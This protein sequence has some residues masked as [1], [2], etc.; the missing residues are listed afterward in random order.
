M[1]QSPHQSDCSCPPCVTRRRERKLYRLQRE[2]GMRRMCDGERCRAHLEWLRE[3]G[4]GQT[5]VAFGTGL[6][7][8]TLWLIAT[9]RRSRVMNETARRI[10]S[11]TP[12]A[13]KAIGVDRPVDATATRL[14]V[15]ALAALGYPQDFIARRCGRS[16][17]GFDMGQRI[18]QRRAL[19][20]LELCREIGDTP[21]PSRK[22]AVQ[23][24][25]RGWCTPAAW[26][27]ELFYDPAWGGSEP[28]TT[29]TI[30]VDR[31][32]EYLR[33]HDWLA[34]AGIVQAEIARRLGIT[35]GYLQQLLN[36]RSQR[37]SKPLAATG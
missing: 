15:Q 28:T 1:G 17:G 37:A 18:S 5:T 9:G 22:A 26:D 24:R 7:E 30:S 13:A 35:P 6:S 8:H 16:R 34:E 10:L 12:E 4:V 2:R 19:A 33:E 3:R 20:V 23:A 29:T 32:E 27:E 11:F 14:R 21:G 25:N 31:A 36:R